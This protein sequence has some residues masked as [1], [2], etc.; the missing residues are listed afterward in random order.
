MTE[1]KADEIWFYTRESRVAVKSYEEWHIEK[2]GEIPVDKLNHLDGFLSEMFRSGMRTGREV[3]RDRSAQKRYLESSKR[4]AEYEAE[5]KKELVKIVV[6]IY[7]ETGKAHYRT[8]LKMCVKKGWTPP[9][10]NDFL[11]VIEMSENDPD[12]IE[13]KKQWFNI[14]GGT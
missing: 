2:Y 8:R 7:S 14:I 3:G 13:M 5:V 9:D 6:G 11:K 1:N 4:E 10:F 12:S